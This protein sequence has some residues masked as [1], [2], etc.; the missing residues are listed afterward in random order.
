M[1]IEK[2]VEQKKP[3]PFVA[4]QPIHKIIILGGLTVAATVLFWLAW[5]NALTTGLSLDLVTQ[6]VL[7]IAGTLFAFCLMFCFLAVTEV[8]VTNKL[9]L[10]L[11]SLV[12]AGTVFIFFSFNLWTVVGALL[13]LLAS[14]YWRHEL[15][16]DLASR[17][18]FMPTRIVNSGLRTAV[19]LLLLAACFVYYGQLTTGQDASERV[20]DQLA[21][22]GNQV[23]QN[24]LRLYYGDKF[25]PQQSLDEFIKKIMLS[26]TDQLLQINTSQPELNK[27]I[28]AGLETVEQSVVDEARDGLLDTFGIQA[29]GSESMETVIGKL[30]KK[31]IDQ[32][33]QPYLKFIP[34]LLAVSL[35]FLLSV[36]GF[37]YREIIKS[38]SYLVFQILFWTHFLTVK[39]VMVEAE[40]IS[41]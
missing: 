6:N 10:L 18:K 17:Q 1:R 33:F 22:S 3:E 12:T 11:I 4:P 20:A 27:V 28:E 41:L 34:V 38:L 5:Q 32:Y 30:A 21:G 26:G 8:V 13:V 7:V 29:T 37:I 15:R 36:F 31:N 16:L 25:Q 9:L 24:I 14:V 2:Q 35:F 23:V 19:S 40:K 39:K